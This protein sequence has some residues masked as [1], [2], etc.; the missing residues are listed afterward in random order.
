MLD[1]GDVKHLLLQ[2][3]GIL[4]FLTE[5]RKYHEIQYFCEIPE[6]LRQYLR[7]TN[8]SKAYNI[9]RYEDNDKWFRW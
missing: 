8:S 2:D 9:H 7:S 6:L 1:V 5:S 3:V 4:Q